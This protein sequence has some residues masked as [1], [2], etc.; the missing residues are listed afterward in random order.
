MTQTANH[1]MKVATDMYYSANGKVRVA[2]L[3]NVWI[4]GK[5]I[6][7]ERFFY[8]MAGSSTVREAL[9][10]AEGVEA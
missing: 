2:K 9:V 8:A 10:F 5:Q 7:G 6:E 1:M 4:V 3:D